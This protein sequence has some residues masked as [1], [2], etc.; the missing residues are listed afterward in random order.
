MTPLDDNMK[1]APKD[2][3][4]L[5]LLPEFSLFLPNWWVGQWSHSQECWAIRTPFLVDN[6]AL[7]MTDLPQPLAW[8]FLPPVPTLE[9]N[10]VSD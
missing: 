9:N 8:K 7:Y 3:T 1:N 2:R 4:I 6:K 5:I 10:N